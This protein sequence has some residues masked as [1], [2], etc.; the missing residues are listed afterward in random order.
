MFA[1]V[2]S[3]LF[4]C[5]HKHL[6]RP[7][8]PVRKRGISQGNTYVVCLDCGQRFAYDSKEWKVGGPLNDDP[9]IRPSKGKETGV[10]PRRLW[11]FRG[12]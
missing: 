11:V 7:V 10:S 2:L 4:Q 12:S 6:S 9:V 5:G 8:A 3:K 1:T